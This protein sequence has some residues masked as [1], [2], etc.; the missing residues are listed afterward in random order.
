MKSKNLKLDIQDLEYWKKK[1]KLAFGFPPLT[2]TG[3][4]PDIIIII[5][6]YL[7]L[8]LLLLILSCLGQSAY[9][10]IDSIRFIAF[11]HNVD[12]CCSMQR[13]DFVDYVLGNKNPTEVGS[14][15]NCVDTTIVDSTEIK[16]ILN[17]LSNLLYIILSF[18]LSI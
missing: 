15:P 5:M 8:N 13:K 14:V 18:T 1:R 10:Q 7:I 11:D 17:T 12:F 9:A 2:I 16:R 4:A 6:K 3:L